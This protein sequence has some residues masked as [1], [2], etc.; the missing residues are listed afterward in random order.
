MSCL[1]YTSTLHE[2][3]KG[4]TEGT[5]VVDFGLR[6]VVQ[7]YN[8]KEIVDYRDELTIYDWWLIKSSMIWIILDSIKIVK[9]RAGSAIT[10]LLKDVYKRQLL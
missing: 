9:L 8:G 2:A 10:L 3:Y 4:Y 5:I 6:V 7:L 1:L